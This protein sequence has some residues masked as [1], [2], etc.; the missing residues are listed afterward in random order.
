MKIKGQQA[1]PPNPAIALRFQFRRH[2]RGVGDPD[3]WVIPHMPHKLATIALFAFVCLTASS[4]R[5]EL[6]I[7]E[8]NWTITTE[9]GYHYGIQGYQSTCYVVWGPHSLFI[10][11]SAYQTVGVFALFL[12]GCTGISLWCHRVSKISASNF[13][14]QTRCSEP[15]DGAPVDNRGSVRRVTDLER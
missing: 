7:F 6:N 10:P 5:G 8:P 9:R 13:T 2:W 1:D 12:C 14:Q 15:G 11:L 4:T 3:R